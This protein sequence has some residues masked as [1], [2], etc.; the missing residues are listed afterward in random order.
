MHTFGFCYK[1][2]FL[3]GQYSAV[4]NLFELS[5]VVFLF[6]ANRKELPHPAIQEQN[7]GIYSGGCLPCS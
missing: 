3:K 1:Q 6:C 7:A 5:E 2:K 4:E